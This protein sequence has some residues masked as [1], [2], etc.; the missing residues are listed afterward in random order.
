M[1]K[2]FQSSD[3]HEKSNEQ[4]D[5]AQDTANK[6]AS[7]AENPITHWLIG[8]TS[9]MKNKNR[10]THPVSFY[11][12]NF[13]LLKWLSQLRIARMK[14]EHGQCQSQEL[15]A[16]LQPTEFFWG[17]LFDGSE[18]KPSLLNGLVKLFHAEKGLLSMSP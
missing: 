14:G 5:V 16:K 2:E 10:H 1:L 15:R 8:W 18:Q 7:Q 11:A 6:Q 13:A 3:K 12:E 17:L 4:M 9:W